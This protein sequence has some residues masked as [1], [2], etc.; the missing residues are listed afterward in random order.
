M[1]AIQILLFLIL[2]VLTANFFPDIL[3]SFW[4]IAGV[5]FAAWIVIV[6]TF[7]G[8][9]FVAGATRAVFQFALETLETV[10]FIVRSWLSL[11][12]APVVKSAAIYRQIKSG[13]E[14]NWPKARREYLA[15]MSG[16]VLLVLAPCVT[17][18]KY[19]LLPLL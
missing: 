10:A 18:V 2:V 3:K 11:A 13:E 9:V 16:W 14:E 17:L 1:R 6:V 12:I 19:F 8:L 5:L 15:T 4:K 7:W